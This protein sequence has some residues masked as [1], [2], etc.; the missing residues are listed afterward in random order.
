MPKIRV[1]VIRF[2]IIWGLQLSHRQE[3]SLNLLMNEL[4]WYRET[5]IPLTCNFPMSIQQQTD[6]MVRVD[7]LLQTWL[8][9]KNFWRHRILQTLPLFMISPLLLNHSF[10]FYYWYKSKI[11]LRDNVVNWNILY[12]HQF[13]L[14]PYYT[15]LCRQN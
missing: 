7:L 5:H 10:H 15:I 6:S 12:Q 11:F 3:A 1:H 14:I 8:L 13:W 4:Y 9:L 2:A